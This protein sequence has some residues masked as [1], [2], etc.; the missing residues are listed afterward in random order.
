[1]PFWLL[2]LLYI[3]TTALSALLAKRPQGP[4]PSSLGDFNAPTATE[5]RPIPIPFGTV[6]L[7]G[8]NVVWYGSLSSTKVKKSA[9]LFGF[10][11]SVIVGYRYFMFMWMALCY[12]PIDALIDIQ[13]GEKSLRAFPGNNYKGQVFTTIAPSL[14][15]ANPGGHTKTTF[16]I[17][18]RMMFGGEFEEGG[19]V[20]TAD[21][22]FGGDDQ[23]SN[24]A[25]ASKLGLSEAPSYNGLSH[26]VLRGF[27]GKGT[28]FGTSNYIKPWAFMV[29]RTTPKVLIPDLDTAKYNISGDMNPAAIIFECLTNEK[30]GLARPLSRMGESWKLVAVALFE[31]GFGLSF[32]QDTAGDVDAFIM[33]IQRHIDAVVYTDP[34]TGLWEIKLARGD[35]DPDALI[36]ITESDLIGAPEGGRPSWPETINEMKIQ[37]VERKRF[38]NPCGG[39]SD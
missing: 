11:A 21:Y 32:L 6:L 8:P 17:D 1:M 28:Y 16:A 9:G 5:D 20:G 37:Y 30:W 23:E 29:R 4:K 2:A 34:L 31:E 15:A 25:I 35:Y 12:G 22:Y 36:E 26:I 19:I 33:E 7:S 27:N 13:I 39:P 18:F 24:S 38:L 3:A 10:G 14:P